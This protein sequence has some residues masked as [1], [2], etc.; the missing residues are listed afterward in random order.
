MGG[1]V[2]SFAGKCCKIK[3]GEMKTVSYD[4]NGRAAD[5]ARMTFR[6]RSPRKKRQRGLSA[7]TGSCRKE[8]EKI[9]NIESVHHKW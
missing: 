2:F 1:Q 7:P 8:V 5:G 3:K 9:Q 6:F 4:R